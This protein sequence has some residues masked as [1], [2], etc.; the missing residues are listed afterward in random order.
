[1]LRAGL[2]QPIDWRPGFMSTPS[3]Q[4]PEGMLSGAMERWMG[5][6]QA[7]EQLN[8]Y[9]R[10]AG[11]LGSSFLTRSMSWV[12]AEAQPEGA[13]W[14]CIYG[15]AALAW[16]DAPPGKCH[17]TLWPIGHQLARLRE[18]HPHLPG[19]VYYGLVDT[20]RRFVNVY[21]WRD[22]RGED[23]AH[24]ATFAGA[25][26]IG[27]RGEDL[28]AA[29]RAPAWLGARSRISAARARELAAEARD[30]WVRKIVEATA[31]LVA[32]GSFAQRERR[33]LSDF[34]I[35]AFDA[36]AE[37]AKGVA[38]ALDPT[39]AGAR[40]TTARVG[41]ELLP[42]APDGPPVLVFAFQD[43]DEIEGYGREAL[44]RTEMFPAWM[45]PVNR[46]ADTILPVMPTVAIGANYHDDRS[47]RS[48]VALFGRCCDALVRATCVL[49]LLRKAKPRPRRAPDPEQVRIQIQA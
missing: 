21:D 26:G 27:R 22:A 29:P 3:R 33:R 48:A 14:L 45:R 16:V 8:R 11:L 18:E 28:G 31:I 41:G 13:I 2:A 12:D 20:L 40:G 42:D 46:T 17:R 39:L 19:F 7:R 38:A 24:R 32:A 36:I 35:S 25:V 5:G 23:E 15:F 47:L 9:F 30:P 37:E 44:R 4:N 10:L 49:D 34:P 1:M 43:H 6:H